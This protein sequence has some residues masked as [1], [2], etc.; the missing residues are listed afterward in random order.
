MVSFSISAAL[1]YD[2]K[3][4]DKERLRLGRFVL[5]TNDFGLSSGTILTSYNGQGSEEGL[6][7]FEG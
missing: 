6:F 3:T 7:R 1:E 2:N 5:A 4:I